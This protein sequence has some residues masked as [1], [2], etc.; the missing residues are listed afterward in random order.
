MDPEYYHNF[1]LTD[2]T[3]VYSYGVV[4]LELLTSEKPVDLSRNPRDANL[5]VR[6]IPL[7][8]AGRVAEILDPRLGVENNPEALVVIEAVAKVGRLVFA[9]SVPMSP[10]VASRN[11]LGPRPQQP[12][13]GGC[14]AWILTEEGRVHVMNSWRWRAW[15]P[16]ETIGPR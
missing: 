16:R 13:A 1:Q 7:I 4:L 6:S 5:A 8:K 10:C 15:Y 2:K 14:D 3:D 12:L 11:E 9:L